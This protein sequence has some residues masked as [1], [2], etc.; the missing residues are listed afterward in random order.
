MG[1]SKFSTLDPSI[2]CTKDSIIYLLYIV[3]ACSKAQICFR[4]DSEPSV[5]ITETCSNNFV[6][7]GR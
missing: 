3:I 2:V 4:N 5:R 7:V 6:N 1:Y